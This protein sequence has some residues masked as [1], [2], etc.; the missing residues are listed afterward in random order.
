MGLEDLFGTSESS[1]DFEEI[2]L[3]FSENLSV[4]LESSLAV[5]ESQWSVNVFSAVEEFVGSENDDSSGDM[6]KVLSTLKA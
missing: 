4:Q 3:F 6:D 2:S 5:E 1:F